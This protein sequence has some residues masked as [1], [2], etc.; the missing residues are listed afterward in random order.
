M[1]TL[2]QQQ[3]DRVIQW[4]ESQASAR[5]KDVPNVSLYDFR[6]TSTCIRFLPMTSDGIH[7]HSHVWTAKKQANV[8]DVRP[9]IHKLLSNGY[10]YT[11]KRFFRRD[12]VT[13]FTVEY[14]ATTFTASE[15]HTRTNGHTILPLAHVLAMYHVN[16]AIRM[17][18]MYQLDGPSAPD[19]SSKRA[20]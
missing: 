2:H 1:S 3:I 11:F 15:T 6:G 10:S 7:W 19:E 5:A 17:Y 18:P 8:T 9:I 4:F 13:R 14:D 12:K 20:E 16:G